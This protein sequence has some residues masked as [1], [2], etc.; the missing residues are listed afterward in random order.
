MRLQ[1]ACMAGWTSE[2]RVSGGFRNMASDLQVAGV[3]AEPLQ[4][5]S[6]RHFALSSVQHLGPHLHASV[7]GQVCGGEAKY[8]T[9]GA[10]KQALHL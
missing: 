4:V 6:A 9:E 3:G 5:R 2:T 1:V 8:L 10:T 7:C